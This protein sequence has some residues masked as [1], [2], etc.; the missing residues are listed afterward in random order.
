MA[1]V[2]ELNAKMAATSGVIH[3]RESDELRLESKCL[4]AT[5]NAGYSLF[6]WTFS[7]GL[8]SVTGRKYT[9]AQ[10]MEMAGIKDPQQLLVR[11][12]EWAD[13][14][15]LIVAF[16]LFT[17]S[18]RLP[19]LPIIARLIKDVTLVQQEC[20]SVR[21]C[22]LV[23][24]DMVTLDLST[25]LQKLTL[26]LP[27]RKEMGELLDAI[28]ATAEVD[29][30]SYSRDHVLN[31]LAGLPANQASNA[32]A[33]AL[34]RTGRVDVATIRS[35][36]KELVAAKGITWIDPDPRGFDSLGG[37]EPVK[38]WA[39]K[40][41]VAF[42]EEKREEY[43]VRAPKG[44]VAGGKPGCA[45]SAFVKALAA[46]WGMT[47]L[48]LDMGATR[49][50]Y[51]G[52]SEQGLEDA[53]LTAEAVSPAILFIDECE[54]AFGGAGTGGATDGGTGER[55]FGAFL[56]WLQEKTSQVFVYLAGNRMDQLPSEF[57]R[58]GRFDATMWFDL[59]TA[60]ERE[61]IVN[62][63]KAKY[64]KAGALDTTALVTASERCTGAEIEA[65][66]EEAALTAMIDA[67]EMTT[68]D[69]VVEMANTTKVEDTFTMSEEL[70]RWRDAALRANADETTSTT[71]VNR[72]RRIRTR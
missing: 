66:F 69:V 32:I 22:Q 35:F 63:F 55:V 52:Q 71:P 72:V 67:R 47:L 26:E 53:I 36:K 8:V 4:Q 37:L 33:E 41:V 60:N 49:G 50:M 31:A 13:G 40:R 62:V 43:G 34:A 27:N 42:D 11:I 23:V 1:F 51:Q 61:S 30:D 28:V 38:A 57:T 16:D 59:P 44:L 70:T 2:E 20:D 5:A 18:N 9:D 14:P 3:V 24:C 58:A 45:K 56:T 48:R 10:R 15:S 7:D 19:S 64:P 54:K 68:E 12:K 21:T 29:P 39:R 25:P 6:R 46:E 17:M 65:A